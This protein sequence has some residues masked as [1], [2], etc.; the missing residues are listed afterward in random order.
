MAMDAIFLQAVV[1]ELRREL[2][3][4][5]IDKVQQPARDQVVLLLRGRRRRSAGKN[6]ISG[7]SLRYQRRYDGGGAAG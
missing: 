2:T 7:V 3:G 4:L 5:R 6:F 1:E